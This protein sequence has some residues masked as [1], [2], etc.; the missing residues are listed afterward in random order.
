MATQANAATSL[1]QL[2]VGPLL[3]VDNKWTAASDGATFER[4]NPYDGS[5]V[6]TYADATQDDIVRAIRSARHAF[7][8][9]EWRRASARDRAGVL[10]R[11]AASI[12]ANADALT[13]LVTCEVGQ[14]GQRGVVLR[15]AEMLEYYAHLITD[16]RDEM[17]SDQDPN[18]IGLIVKEPVGAVGVLTNWN[19]PMSL[20]HK[21]CPAIAAGC[22]VVLKPSHLTPGTAL[23]IGRF[24]VEAGLPPGVLNIVTSAR[25][26]GVMAGQTMAGSPLFDMIAFTGSTANGRKVMAA[27]AANLTR[28]SLELGGKSPHIIFGDVR[29][30]DKA[31]DAAFL[32]VTTLGGQACQAGSRLL[33]H[34]SI[35]AEVVAKLKTKFE[36]VRL[37]DPLDPATTMGPMVSAAHQARVIS[38]IEDGKRC[39]RLVTGGGKPTNPALAGGHFVQPSL[40]DGVANDALIARD[41]I[42]GPVLAIMPFRDEGEAIALA[43]DTMFGLAA[44]VWTEDIGVALRV[45]KAIRSGTVWVN[46]FRESGLWTMPAGGF[47]QSGIGRERG[48]EGLD[49]FLETKS[50]HVRY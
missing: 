35:R 45:A 10:T 41:E 4:R 1:K 43:N 13:E 34:E 44:G 9:G 39:A 40:F 24:F 29:S 30:V 22:S 47:K 27:C 3:L 50:I 19:S 48:R 11:V 38:Y 37:G 31:V 17:V 21:G 2:A 42:F 49:V 20:A 15:A 28:V 46:A 16:R 7:D 18:A 23:V 6:G 12:R 36:S 5:L 8:K 26:D 32:G 25:E 14:P 33:V